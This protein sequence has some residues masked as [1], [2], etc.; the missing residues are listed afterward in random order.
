MSQ[1]ETLGQPV[2]AKPCVPP[3]ELYIE[4]LGVGHDNSQRLA[5]YADDQRLRYLELFEERERSSVFVCPYDYAAEARQTHRL[6]LEVATQGE[7]IR[8]PLTEPGGLAPTAYQAMNQF[9]LIT[10]A[11][12]V[13]SVSW[14]PAVAGSDP[15]GQ[16]LTPRDGFIYLF[17]GSTLW[18]EIAVNSSASGLT[19]ADVD[20]CVYRKAAG[21]ASSSSG[22]KP[23]GLSTDSFWFPSQL[24]DSHEFCI[25]FSEYQ[26]SWTHIQWLEADSSRLKD[27]CAPMAHGIYAWRNYGNKKELVSAD[28]LTPCLARNEDLESLYSQPHKQA[29]D[30]HGDYQREQRR[31]AETTETDA[32]SEQLNPG[33]RWPALETKL[34]LLRPDNLKTGTLDN[35]YPAP[36]YA[37]VDQFQRARQQRLA[38]FWVADI[39]YLQDHAIEQV[40]AT[41][42]CLKLLNEAISYQPHAASAQ[43]INRFVLASRTMTGQKNPLYDKRSA[44]DASPGS[45][46]DNTLLNHARSRHRTALESQLALLTQPMKSHKAKQLL[47]HWRDLFSH[48]G[49]GYALGFLKLDQLADTLLIAP[50]NCDAAILPEQ[51]RGCLK[52]NYRAWLSWFES[53]LSE[54]LGG[55]EVLANDGSGRFRLADYR[56]IANPDWPAWRSQAQTRIARELASYHQGLEE[57]GQMA[58]AESEM[59]E[60]DHIAAARTFTNG[61][62]SL[63]GGVNLLFLNSLAEEY[64]V[65]KKH[66]FFARQLTIATE[67]VN[68]NH[69]VNG[70]PY[71]VVIDKSPFKGLELEFIKVV[72]RDKLPDDF[73]VGQAPGGNKSL[74][75][76]G[77]TLQ[78]TNSDQVAGSA[79]SRML[80]AS[81][82]KQAQRLD[83]VYVLAMERLF[84]GDAKQSSSGKISGWLRKAVANPKYFPPMI[85][86]FDLWNLQASREAWSQDR[87]VYTGMS[88]L[89]AVLDLTLAN[90]S[91][92]ALANPNGRVA[93][94]LNRHAFSIRQA[95]ISQGLLGGI[96]AGALT[97]SLQFANAYRLAGRDDD[98]AMRAQLVQG[99]GTVLM[100]AG[101]LLA[102]LI[103]IPMLGWTL[104]GLT[105]VIG[106]GIALATAQDTPLERWLKSGP[107]AADRHRDQQ[108]TVLTGDQVRAY[109]QLLFALF[110]GEQQRIDVLDAPGIPESD[111]QL[112]GLSRNDPVQAL[113][114]LRS[115]LL[116]R[117]HNPDVAPLFRA[118]RQRL[119]G[120]Y[121][122]SQ[123][124]YA[125]FGP[126]GNAEPLRPIKGAWVET[127]QGM[128]YW[129][130]LAGAP[131]TTGQR[132]RTQV[133]AFYQ[134]PVPWFN[135]ATGQQTSHPLR[136]PLPDPE[137]QLAL[138]QQLPTADQLPAETTADSDPWW[139]HS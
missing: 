88:T 109:Q 135:P 139:W 114:K 117:L 44:V 138:W 29:Q 134:P 54:M 122:H 79:S 64:G 137:T 69:F 115:P 52:E 62:N 110:D 118:N 15:A 40:Q 68:N 48:D 59:A 81:Y 28:E 103:G 132:S 10:A 82:A 90:T 43:L 120:T 63:L 87:S 121:I 128:E 92:A 41:A 51:S 21:S 27:R 84:T 2:M 57:V 13:T 42:H 74:Q 89:S 113:A 3:G 50:E 86:A 72:R 11:I 124:H 76:A 8:L 12:P 7:P 58:A 16:R 1:Q 97:A 9:H 18:R 70:S 45:T 49:Q 5:V 125:G 31:L 83:A 6:V 105:L 104:L 96:L 100:S 108:L 99:T 25:A 112:L 106:G 127:G 47:A 23:S 111:L 32:I 33:L 101:P 102:G 131:L 73:A 75:F 60:E 17:R 46:L 94:H 123:G 116:S 38:A 56:Q 107:F 80:T 133:Q 53:G 119:Q 35:P 39:R 4:V 61:G 30:L 95:H 14:A 66:A 34:D 19:F 55:D 26:W 20:L 129:L 65:T 130:A 126:V 67:L 136:F 85:V 98:D 37:G 71:K 24:P 91:M 22:R 93:S 77:K 36:Q 78:I